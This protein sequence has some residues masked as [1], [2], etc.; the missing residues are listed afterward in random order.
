M[1]GKCGV[2]DPFSGFFPFSAFSTI[3]KYRFWKAQPGRF[4]MAPWWN[5]VALNQ[6]R[7]QKK[8]NVTEQE[9]QRWKSVLENK[10]F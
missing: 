7:H 8:P 10:D 3:D 9:K 6:L 4:V 5:L 1:M 2:V